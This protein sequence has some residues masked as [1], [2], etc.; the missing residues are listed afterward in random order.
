[1]AVEN[2]PSSAA[3]SGAAGGGLTGNYPNPMIGP[4]KVTPDKLALGGVQLASEAAVETSAAEPKDIPGCAYVAPADG[5]Y[6]ILA[7]FDVLCQ[8]AGFNCTG[9]L[10]VDGVEQA[11]KA[12]FSGVAVNERIPDNTFWLVTCKAGKT[13]K[14][15]AKKTGGKYLVEPTH[16]KMVV[17]PLG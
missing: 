12:I 7:D 2:P 5:T 17:I 11:S 14:L 16:T 8:E 3:P 6:L 10:V 9:T 1:M 13:I 4:K 15:Q